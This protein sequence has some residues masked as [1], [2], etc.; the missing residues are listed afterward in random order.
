VNV[1]IS[2]TGRDLLTVVKHKYAKLPKI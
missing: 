2:E 1:S